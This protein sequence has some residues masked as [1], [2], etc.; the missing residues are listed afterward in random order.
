[1]LCFKQWCIGKYFYEYTYFDD[2]NEREGFP[3]FSFSNLL[4]PPS[5]KFSN[6]IVQLVKLN[7]IRT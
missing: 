5:K 4:S 2:K 7:N 1:M 3:S 6:Y